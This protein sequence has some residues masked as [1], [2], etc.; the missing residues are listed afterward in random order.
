MQLC[1]SNRQP[2]ISLPSRRS[3]VSFPSPWVT[4]HVQCVWFPLLS[5]FLSRN[6]SSEDSCLGVSSGRGRQLPSRIK[7]SLPTPFLTCGF[8]I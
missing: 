4:L 2:F 3:P 6:S 5:E 7:D 1:S 8:P